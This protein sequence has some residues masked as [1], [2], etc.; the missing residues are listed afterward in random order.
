MAN[1][2]CA[3]RWGPNYG[4][5]RDEENKRGI[6]GNMIIHN[7]KQRISMPADLENSGNGGKNEE[8]GER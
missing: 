1:K 5:W 7:N 6:S 3:V 8:M 2:F 4:L